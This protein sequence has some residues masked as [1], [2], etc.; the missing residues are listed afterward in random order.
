MKKFLYAVVENTRP[1]SPKLLFTSF[2][3][4]YLLAIILYTF[5]STQIHQ[6]INSFVNSL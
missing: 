1:L 5:Y 3:S 2:I 4:G 6:L